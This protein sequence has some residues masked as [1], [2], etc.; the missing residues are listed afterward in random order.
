MRLFPQYDVAVGGYGLTIGG[1][2]QGLVVG[3]T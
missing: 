1:D 3:K 2:G